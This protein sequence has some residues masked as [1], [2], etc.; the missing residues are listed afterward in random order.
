MRFGLIFAAAFAALVIG[1]TPA[2]ADTLTF[3]ETVG[4]V[5]WGGGALADGF[6]IPGLTA[7]AGAATDM[8]GIAPNTAFSGRQ[9]MFN[10][11]TREARLL[12]DSAFDM[13]GAWFKDDVRGNI[14]EPSTFRATGYDENGVLLYDSV[15][16]LT[17]TWTFIAINM[18]GISDFR[19]NPLN[20]DVQ[21]MQMDDLHYND[22]AAVPEPST[23]ALLGLGVI[24][25]ALRSRRK[26]KAKAS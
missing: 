13:T 24:G 8:A 7:T 5:P 25:I 23:L 9:A 22:A 21:N 2:Q 12:R 18:S 17:G 1:A 6:S 26:M 11:N 16:E 14:P 19:F 10:Y 15:H 3:D 20:P 4:L